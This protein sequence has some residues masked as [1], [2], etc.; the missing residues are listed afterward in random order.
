VKLAADLF[1]AAVVV[2][3]AIAGGALAVW[4]LL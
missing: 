2:G 4:W 1:L 3:L